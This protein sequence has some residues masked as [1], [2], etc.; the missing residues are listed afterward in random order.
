MGG[1]VGWVGGWL[2]GWVGGLIE[3]VDWVGGLVGWVDWMNSFQHQ[4]FFYLFILFIPLLPHS[5]IACKA[6][7]PF[8]KLAID[9]LK[10]RLDTIFRDSFSNS[11]KLT[12]FQ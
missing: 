9:N 3:W 12:I 1:L 11:L 6:R 7:H 10:V 4:C 2:G 8:L 5:F